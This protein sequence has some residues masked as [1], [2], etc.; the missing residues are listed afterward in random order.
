MPETKTLSLPFRLM[1][2]LLYL[3]AR[4]VL[5]TSKVVRIR[6]DE[7]KN[8]RAERPIILAQWHEHAFAMMITHRNQYFYP[9]AS[10]S[11][12]GDMVSAVSKRLGLPCVRGSSSR[13]GATARKN[14]GELLAQNKSVAFTVDGPRGPRHKVKPGCVDVSIKCNAPIFPVLAFAQKSWILRKT[15]DQTRIP[16]PFSKIYLIYAPPIYPCENFDDQLLAVENALM[17]L[18]AEAKHLIDEKS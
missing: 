3:F 18:E 14:L 7:M 9:V 12:D 16:K 8:I 11:K 10:L 5:L 13:G 1:C 15:W 17:N 2:Y 6:V 4:L